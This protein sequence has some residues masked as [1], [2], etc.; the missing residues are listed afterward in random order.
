MKF[1]AY[2][3][4]FLFFAVVPAYSQ[5][6]FSREKF[7]VK[8]TKAILISAAMLEIHDKPKP[9]GDAAFLITDKNEITRF[10]KL[11]DEKSYAISHACG[12][13]WRITFVGQSAETTEVW[14]NQNCEE[15][16]KNTAEIYKLARAKFEQ[17]KKNPTHFISEIGVDVNVS[18]E[19][20]VKRINENPNFNA[21]ILGDANKRFPFIEIE[22]TA[23]SDIPEDRKLWDKAKEETR[24][25]A[26]MLLIEESK[27]I[28]QNFAVLKNDEFQFNK[29]MFGG[30][31]IEESPCLK[32][33][34]QVGTK[35][36][37]IE[38]S[39]INS[40][41]IKK[42]EPEVYFLQLVSKN[43]FSD[44]FSNQLLTDFPFIKQSFAYTSYAR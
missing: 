37:N 9:A 24:K 5:E 27:R 1:I 16:E 14:F 6:K 28:S 26:E 35:L 15:F 42:A 4:S 40:K 41:I 36:D 30:G 33:Y 21:F 31:K 11:F 7:S 12:Y 34:F 44:L 19:E 32:I 3:L 25:K 17:I 22:A 20:A 23:V 18:V 13:H 43:R 38:K 29:S 8:N 10:V 2:C 39:L